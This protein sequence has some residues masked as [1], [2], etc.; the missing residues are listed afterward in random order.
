MARRR[1]AGLVS[2]FAP[3]AVVTEAIDS[4]MAHK[5]KLGYSLSHFA[6]MVRVAMLRHAHDII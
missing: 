6:W 2:G 3:F 5:A 1:T 4:Q